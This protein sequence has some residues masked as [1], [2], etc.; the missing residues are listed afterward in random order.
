MDHGQ[1][2]VRGWESRVN[3]NVVGRPDAPDAPDALDA[4]EV[5][6][7]RSLGKLSSDEGPG[8]TDT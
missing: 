6:G 2:R 5:T 3:R 4:P 1:K 8:A 7:I